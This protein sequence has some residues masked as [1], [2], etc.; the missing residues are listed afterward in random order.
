VSSI[1]AAV[2][3]SGFARL[4][5]WA[6]GG[7]S[8]T[9][10]GPRT[11]PHARDAASCR[12]PNTHESP[13]R[14]HS[15]WVLA[16]TALGRDV[17][18]PRAANV[19]ALM[20][21]ATQSSKALFAA[22][23]AV[24]GCQEDP[25]PP[26]PTVPSSAPVASV[27]PPP[28][29]TASAAAEPE[30][31]HDCP[32]GSTG[33]GSFDKPCEAKGSARL[34]EVAWTGKMTDAG[35]TFRVTNKSTLPILYGT[36]AAYFYDKQGKQLTVTSGGKPRPKQVCSGKIFAGV[37][38]PAEKAVLTFSCVKKDHVPEGT[39]AIEAEIHTV[40]FSDEAGT[41]TEFYWRNEGL[42]PDTR[43]KGGG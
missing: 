38:K 23:L 33:P 9:A 24:V 22:L 32:Q 19:E 34:M 35:P 36:I 43:K 39:T 21:V 1:A 25:P 37:M 29:A 11:L 2:S 41:K 4:P 5:A 42:A 10:N 3:S 8:R 20:S 15:C 31:Q 14:R 26:K 16:R 30:P 12:A 40:G 18:G 28:S 17:S 7:T 6:S 13:S 27:K